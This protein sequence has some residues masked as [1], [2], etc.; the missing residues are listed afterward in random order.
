LSALIGLLKKN[1]F[2]DF[3]SVSFI[4]GLNY[5]VP[6][7]LM[8]YVVR[9]LGPEYF[10]LASFSQSFV[11]YFTLIINYGFDLSATREVAKATGNMQRQ[12][13]IFNEILQVKIFLFVISSILFLIILAVTPKLKE[14]ALL[15]IVSYLINIGAV[16]FPMWFFQG[17]NRLKIATIF[18]FSAKVFMAL[19]VVLFVHN[20]NDYIN[21]NG[22]LSFAQIML[23]ISS[24][25]YVYKKYAI[26]LRWIGWLKMRVILKQGLSLFLSM[27]VINFYS[28]S[29]V[30]ILGLLSTN[31]AAGY[32]SA[33]S[34]IIAVVFN[35]I[36]IP[37]S[38]IL[39]PKIGFLLKQDYNNGLVLFKK[40]VW[41]SLILGVLMSL[42]LYTFSN[43]VVVIWLGNNFSPVVKLLK[44]LSP[45]P[46]FISLTNAFGIQG[47]LNLNNDKIF[48]KI[49]TI[50]S[51]ICIV[52]NLILVKPYHEYGAAFSW[53]VA[54]LFITVASF[55]LLKKQI[56]Y[57]FDLNCLP[58]KLYTKR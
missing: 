13:Q 43:L 44:F 36:L 51:I 52:S 40:N 5:L 28:A 19:L 4:Q 2:K 38:Y 10:G 30:F 27:I 11:L 12:G 32:L 23:G 9:R 26:Q 48:L 8:P 1:I 56:L 22:T 7:L 29:N 17:I 21:Y 24:F 46:L 42:V 25:I 49:T 20:T 37:L 50:G 54:E 18:N 53:I 33:A 58:F 57:V 35:T 31:A 14:H 45:I 39:Y 55:V 47:L 6:L 16:L 34:K 15:H 41:I 3:L